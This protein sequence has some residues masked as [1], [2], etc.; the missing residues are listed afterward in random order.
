MAGYVVGGGSWRGHTLL[1]KEK[2]TPVTLVE[3]STHCSGVE[4]T[5]GV[6]E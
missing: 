4:N 5:I 1:A 6:E 2:Q 3:E